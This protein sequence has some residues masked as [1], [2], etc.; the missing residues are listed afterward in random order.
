VND[1]AKAD[2]SKQG[3]PYHPLADIFPLIEEG[4]FEELV[5]DIKANG[6][7][8]RIVLHE[9]SILD[10]RNR[11]RACIEAGLFKPSSKSSDHIEDRKHFIS[12]PSNMDAVSFVV[13]KNILRRHLD[14]GQRA[15]AAAQL[16]NMRQGERTDCEHSANLRKVSQADAAR[17]LNVSER[18]VTD[19]AKVLK[20]AEPEIVEAMKDGKLAA[21]VARAA[22]DLAP[23][24]QKEI[25]AQAK[26]GD[27]KGAGKKIKEA[28]A[29]K[30][31]KVSKRGQSTL[32]ED[33]AARAKRTETMDLI[34]GVGKLQALSTEYGL[35]HS[36]G[37]E[38][39]P[40][41]D[42]LLVASYEDVTAAYGILGHIK[43]A[44]EREQAADGSRGEYSPPAAAVAYTAVE[45][46]T[47]AVETDAEP[48]TITVITDTEA[49]EPATNSVL[50]GSTPT[51]VPVPAQE[52]A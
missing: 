52:A 21:S 26:K 29:K 10:G 13:S 4:K 2:K 41:P 28:K 34:I 15:A 33:L 36:D 23:A 22:A 37:Y 14:E 39:K 16:A 25:A 44:M 11:Y 6:L 18:S 35:E 31:K 47:A 49:P 30:P 1:R 32:P 27:R 42:H 19:A 8:D 20:K 50:Q 51:I 48:Y 24:D 46:A 7:R 43:Y 17:L 12:L 38:C 40:V 45:P 5:A 9:G 3:L